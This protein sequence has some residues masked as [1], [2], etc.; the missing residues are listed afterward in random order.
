M[1]EE[2]LFK[3]K[4]IYFYSIVFLLFFSFFY[5]FKIGDIIFKGYR[6]IAKYEDFKIPIY[7]LF[8]VTFISLIFSLINIFKE[9]K[10]AVFYFNISIFFMICIST[11]NLYVNNLFEKTPPFNLIIF[12]G[13]FFFSAFLINYF[14]HKPFQNEINEIGKSENHL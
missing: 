14:K 8:F 13:F 1:H 2:R 3:Y 11:I 6:I 7:I 12:F 10:K 5:F 4:F 9:S